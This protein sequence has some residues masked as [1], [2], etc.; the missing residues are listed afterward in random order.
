MGYNIYICVCVCVCLYVCLC[1]CLCARVYN[2]FFLI[3]LIL[4]LHICWTVLSYPFNNT[5]VICSALEMEDFLWFHSLRNI[6]KES[7][8]TSAR[9]IFNWVK[10]SILIGFAHQMINSILQSSV[11]LPVDQNIRYTCFKSTLW[12]VAMKTIPVRIQRAIV[13][14]L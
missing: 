12:S 10:S 5:H 14:R 2:L 1:L 6:N 13:I 8:F 3:T 4:L 7:L 11:L 9:I